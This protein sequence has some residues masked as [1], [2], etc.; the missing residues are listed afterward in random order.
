MF[1]YI[2]IFYA[3]MIDVFAFDQN[4]NGL[5]FTGGAIILI[6]SVLAALH[7]KIMDQKKDQDSLNEV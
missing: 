5:Q 2:Q 4:L 7:K 1:M 3:Y 6:F